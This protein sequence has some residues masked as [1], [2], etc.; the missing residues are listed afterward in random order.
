M[1]KRA[2]GGDREGKK[3]S[4]DGCR[5][6]ECSAPVHAPAAAIPPTY[7][8]PIPS[9][10]HSNIASTCIHAQMYGLTIAPETCGTLLGTRHGSRGALPW[11]PSLPS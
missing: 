3:V 4:R 5:D 10:Q 1:L 8:P 9:F 11:H 2:A 7:P 6:I